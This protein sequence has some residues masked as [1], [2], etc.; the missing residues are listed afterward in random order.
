MAA[1]Q[2]IDFFQTGRIANSVNFPLASLE[3]SSG[4]RVA[5]ANHNSPGLLGNITSIL[6]ERKINVV[7]LLNKSRDEVAYNHIDLDQPADE[8]LLAAIAKVEGVINVRSINL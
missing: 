6:A 4:W 2:L 1:E 7:D 3:A 8:L 5:I